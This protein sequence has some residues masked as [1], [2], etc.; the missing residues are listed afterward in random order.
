MFKKRILLLV[1]L[2]GSL[3]LQAA[4]RQTK[5]TMLVVPRDPVL[6]QIA[7]DI[8]RRYPALLVCYQTNGAQTVIHAWDGK[9]WGEI[10]EKDY[11]NGAFF[12]LN[13][14]HAVI[15]EDEAGSAPD[16]VIPDGSWCEAGNRIATTEP[17]AVLHLLG[18][19]FDFPYSYWVQFC[20]RYHFT[21][22]A[23]NPALLNV[24]WWHYRGKDVL[25]A[26]RARNYNADMDKWLYLDM[27]PAAPVLPE[28]QKDADEITE[29][30]T[31]ADESEPVLEPASDESMEELFE[32]DEYVAVPASDLTEE[33]AVPESIEKEMTDEPEAEAPAVEEN[34]EAAPENKEESKTAAIMD[35]LAG[36]ASDPAAVEDPA[37]AAPATDVNPFSSVDIPAAKIIPTAK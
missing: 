28:V 23:I 20:R 25:P 9:T 36:L 24:P 32:T 14:R 26:M 11:I 13:P 6:V 2:S 35:E 22:E 4:N 10:P 1:I 29:E 17:R 7:L 37:P 30:P 12:K 21:L 34:T 18:R 19:Y 5:I 3:Q 16:A 33:A 15:V 8:S 27:S 31:L